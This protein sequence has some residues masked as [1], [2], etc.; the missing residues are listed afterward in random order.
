M[1]ARKKSAARKSSSS[2]KSASKKS[3]S[4]KSAAKKKSASSRAPSDAI[5][6]LRADHK[7]VQDLFQQFE[8]TRSDDRKRALAEQI[9]TE[10]TIHAQIEEEIFYPAARG[11]IREEDLLDEAEVEHQ[12]AKDLIAQIESG[13]PDDELWEAKVKVLGEYINHLV[14][15]EQNEMFP[16]VKKTKLDLKALGEQLQ[17][18][19]MELQGESGGGGS[20]GRSGGR[21]GGR[22]GGGGAKKNGGAESEESGGGEGEG[23]VA[24]MAR[25]IGLGGT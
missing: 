14:K 9:C 10:L 18:R 1:A 23:I 15:E 16:Q 2:K 12:S 22:S 19:K 8:K 20:R 5:A 3:A 25:G 24:R 17:A 7:T 4:K 6:L 13:S 21:N 11:A